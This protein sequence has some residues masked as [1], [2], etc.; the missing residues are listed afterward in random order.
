MIELNLVAELQP[1]I[2]NS[3]LSFFKKNFNTNSLISAIFLSIPIYLYHINEN[4]FIQFL[5]AVFTIL[6]FFVLIKKNTPL[7]SFGSFIGLFWFW[8]ISLSFKYYNLTW[9][10]PIVTILIA[11][12][13]GLIFKFA[14][15]AINF[16]SQKLNN[17]YEFNWEKTLLIIF[18]VFGLDFI[19]PFTFDWLKFDIL[20]LTFN[21]YLNKFVFFIFLFSFL[22]KR[23]YFFLIPLILITTTLK[24]LPLPNIK[25]KLIST[26][27]PQEKK[28]DKNYISTQIQNNL[29]YIQQAIKEKYEVVVL[30][31]SAF[32]L[33]LNLHP[34]L[35]QKLK[36]LSQKITIITGALHYKNKNF[37]N[38]TYIFKKGKIKILDKHLLVPF[39]EYIP[40]PIFQKEINK[41]FFN[42][43][44]DYKTSKDFGEFK[45][46]N[47]K[48]L[49][50]I[51]YEATI[52]KLY[53]KKPKYIIAIS[54]MAWFYPSIAPTLQKLLIKFYS[55]KYKK[56]I[57]HSLNFYK[58]YIV[59]GGI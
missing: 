35:L 56:I 27:I 42:G 38:S 22:I 16:I 41:I 30:P 11:M 2:K 36:E 47:Y 39:G 20:F 9:L 21:H 25:I 18:I 10:I 59:K 17:Y 6:G 28:W 19:K 13:Y 50:A 58:S 4:I 15:I 34:K 52:E 7:F 33:F 57:F 46:K 31:E 43:A 32:P 40:F 55:A 8:W 49:N 48:F 29:S 53:Q 54:N 5:C 24:P 3:C 23:T 37:Y 26:Y 12:G 51:C 1:R 44:S 14:E 45:I